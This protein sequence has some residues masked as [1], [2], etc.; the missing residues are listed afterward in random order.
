MTTRRELLF[1]LIAAALGIRAQS[2]NAVASKPLAFRDMPWHFWFVHPS[3]RVSGEM[4]QNSAFDTSAARN[5]V[6]SDE[7]SSGIW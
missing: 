6:F 5:H 7:G 2:A 4:F 3:V 1:G